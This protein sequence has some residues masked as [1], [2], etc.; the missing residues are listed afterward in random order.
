MRFSCPSIYIS[1]T[2]DT[3]RSWVFWL[4]RRIGRAAQED[5]GLSAFASR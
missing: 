5:G 2:A 4:C 1:H 3:S